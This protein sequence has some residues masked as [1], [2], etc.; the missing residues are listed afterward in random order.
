M[1]NVSPLHDG[2]ALKSLAN[3]S[4]LTAS[5]FTTSMNGAD[6]GCATETVPAEQAR[7]KRTTNHFMKP[8]GLDWR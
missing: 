7:M 5:V 4:P 2:S 3:R 8:S 6:D 1:C